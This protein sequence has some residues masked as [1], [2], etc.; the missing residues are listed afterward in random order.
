MS[1]RPGSISLKL[2]CPQRRIF[3]YQACPQRQGG[4]GGQKMASR[5]LHALHCIP[6]REVLRLK[7]EQRKSPVDILVVDATEKVP[8]GNWSTQNFP[9]GMASKFVID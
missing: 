9:N 2:T 3:S 5:T 8:T 6:R 1:R 7:L 4:A